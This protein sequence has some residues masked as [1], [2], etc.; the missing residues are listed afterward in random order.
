MRVQGAL[1]GH[2]HRLRAATGQG[3][4]PP[5]SSHCLRAA[6]F[7]MC[8]F[9]QECKKYVSLRYNNRLKLLCSEMRNCVIMPTSADI[10][11]ITECRR[12]T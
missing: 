5:E 6:A 3:Q 2:D 8:M 9:V 12:I 1:P 4:S 7:K 11:V 10:F